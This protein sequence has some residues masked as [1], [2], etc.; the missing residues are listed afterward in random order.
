M[1]IIESDFRNLNIRYNLSEEI[2]KKVPKVYQ[3]LDG[4]LGFANGASGEQGIPYWFSFDE[5][6]KSISASV[7]PGGLQLC[8]NNID[9]MEWE[10]WLSEAKKH[11]T[12]ILG[13]KVGEIEL[14]EVGNE[15]EWLNS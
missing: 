7:E 1:A 15:I 2:W 3:C 13:F 14:G 8:A 4:W 9:E 6:E 11:A 12:R 10:A 5:T